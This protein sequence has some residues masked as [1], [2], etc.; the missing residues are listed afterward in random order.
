MSKFKITRIYEVEAHDKQAALHAL[1]QSNWDLT[2][3][4]WQGMT[5]VRTEQKS[6]ATIA[7]EQWT[8]KPS[9]AR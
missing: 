9:G 5:E 3:L 8:G 4:S 6:W 7:K 2:Y 1:N